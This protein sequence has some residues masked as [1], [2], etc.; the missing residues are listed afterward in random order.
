MPGCSRLGD[1]GGRGIVLAMRTNH[2]GRQP[3]VLLLALLAP[4][5]AVA[6]VA[7]APPGTSLPLSGPSIVRGLAL[8]VDMSPLGRLGGGDTPAS[9]LPRAFTD[10]VRKALTKAGVRDKEALDSL[11]ARFPVSGADIYRLNCRSCHGP[12]GAGKPPAVA[13]IIG[14]SRALSPAQHEAAMKAAGAEPKPEL[15]RELA[16][17]A[18]EALR[19]RLA[20]GGN[21]PDLPY[22]ETMPPFAYLSEPEVVALADYLKQLGG[23]APTGAAVQKVNQSALRIGEQVVRGT[24]RVCHDATGAAGGHALMTSGLVPALANLPE[25]MSLDGVVHKVRHGWTSM[26]EM[27]TPASRMPVFPYLSNEEVA[28]AY[29]YLAY[30]PPQPDR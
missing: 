2:E 19:K 21:K 4:A 24:C 10:S 7:P 18:Q 22:L 11:R 16:L 17:H 23:V 1:A 12:A 13:S 5:L 15:A 8:T 6:Q 3:L 25:Q 9:A 26:A 14:P 30:L 29:L 28:A 20:K 27:A